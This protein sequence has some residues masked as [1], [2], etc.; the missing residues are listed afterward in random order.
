MV[1]Q[2]P[3]KKVKPLKPA[4]STFWVVPTGRVVMVVVGS[5]VVVVDVVLVEGRLEFVGSRAGLGLV[6]GPPRVVVLESG[7]VVLLVGLD[8]RSS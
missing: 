4:P 7:T 3:P 2:M 5:L 8:G 6:E 1:K